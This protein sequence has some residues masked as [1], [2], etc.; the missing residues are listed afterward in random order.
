MRK[1]ISLENSSVTTVERDRFCETKNTFRKTGGAVRCLFF[2]PEIIGIQIISLVREEGGWDIVARKNRIGPEDFYLPKG[3]DRRV[4]EN[5]YPVAAA[6]KL[7]GVTIG[8]CSELRE[9]IGEFN[10]N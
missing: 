7:S 6:D 8:V 10:P 9:F 5:R 2:Q 3:V 1:E 4:F